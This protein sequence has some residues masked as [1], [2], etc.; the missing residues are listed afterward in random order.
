MTN[1]IEEII[2]KNILD[3]NH[4]FV[5]PTQTAADMWADRATQI[6]S[7][8]AVAKERFIAWDK[9]K[10]T[11]IKS[12]NQDKTAVPAIMRKIFACQLIL[13]NEKKTFL[14]NLIPQEFSENA[15]NFS[16]WIARLLPGLASWKRYF[17]ESGVKS[18][19]QDEDLLK[20]YNKYSNFLER[21]KL[22]DPAWET[23][24][25]ESCGNSYSIFFPEILSDYSEYKTILEKTQNEIKIIPV[26][27]IQINKE[28]PDS[29]ISFFRNSRKELKAVAQYLFDLHNQQKIEWQD[30]AVSVPDM[31][32]YGTYIMREFY[33]FQIPFVSRY[34]VP[35]AST[36]AGI[37]FQS[38][39]DCFL[40]DFNYE[41][42][43]N[44]LLNSELPWSDT[45][46]IQQLIKFGK[47]NHCICNFMQ[48]GKKIDVWENSFREK[49]SE[50]RSRN[51]YNELKK[52]ITNIV[53]SKTFE[54]VRV[55]Y[56]DFRSKFFDMSK[57]SQNSD[58]IL[59][60]C[61]TE[62]SEIID[63]EQDF[64][65]CKT[66]QPF[67]FFVKHLKEVNYLAQT[68]D[69]GV[70]ILP[71]K[72]SACAP[73]KVQVV[74]DASQK[75]TSIIYK[76]LPFLLD[77]KRKKLL[78]IN[79]E[80]KNVS[81][82]FIYLYFMN[83]TAEKTLFTCAEK[84]FAGY[85]Q[86]TSYIDQKD[87]FDFEENSDIAENLFLSEK[88][89]TEENS[90]RITKIKKSGLEFWFKSHNTAEDENNDCKKISSKNCETQNK[91]RISKSDLTTFFDCPRK[92]Y[93]SK[94]LKL[95][96]E[97]NEAELV[98]P[99]EI[100]ELNHK[101]LE[102]F[103]SALK[104]RKLKLCLNSN[105]NLSEEYTKILDN[106]IEN[107]IETDNKI[108]F[109]TRNLYKTSKQNIRLSIFEAVSEFCKIFSG[110]EIIEIENEYTY[111]IPQKNIILN[112][113]IDCLLFD[114][115]ECAFILIDFKSTNNAIPKNIYF[116]IDE[117]KKE[118][119]MDFQMPM[120]I[121]LLQNQKKSIKIENACFFPL[122]KNST[123]GKFE[124]KAVIGQLAF[125]AL[126]KNCPNTKAEF[127]SIE[128][129]QTEIAKMQ[130][131]I[132]EFSNRVKCGN[133]EPN[134]QIQDYSKCRQCFYK[135]ICRTSFTVGKPN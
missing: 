54:Q 67:L 73:F 132:F 119:L 116:S 81:Q 14:Q 110:C 76:E 49:N 98:N 79:F 37:F 130:Q 27:E 62:L 121:Y 71:Y 48:D 123:T 59:S 34:A 109:L 26:P 28:F 100:G 88:S 9:F 128:N 133:F 5:F 25:F 3:Q 53:E 13:D 56:F 40:S 126:K 107:T 31:Q 94:D 97:T 46:S 72:L 52:K 74:V 47:E 82:L 65:D 66:P 63:L 45:V 42:I 61:I 92:W 135:S 93:F 51:F 120:Y 77:N 70:S 108:S 99:Y 113:K 78:G 104:E 131:C 89:Q 125:D 102:N 16:S 6:S 117:N 90:E 83:S 115:A 101:I 18:D 58:N 8:K 96:E 80:E 30:I 105:F 124:V 35:L 129:F 4:R 68:K 36:G 91:I 12:K 20:I 112:G 10:Q 69:L 60:R 38:L 15:Q 24:P 84:T 122:K 21:Y 39:A 1:I 33:L 22:F 50:F 17:D 103:C 106:A 55:S 44:L 114:P 57:C 86:P 43:R 41:S 85:A 23:P 29:K 87:C 64:P 7:T 11:S 75:S 2:C 118:N 19:L 95:K 134:P 32:T 111:D 127:H